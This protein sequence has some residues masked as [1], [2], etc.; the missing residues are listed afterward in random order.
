M[1]FRM[2]VVLVGG[3]AF[4]A[5]GALVDLAS[6][7]DADLAT[8]CAFHKEG[9][10]VHRCQERNAGVG[11]KTYLAQFDGTC[12]LSQG[13]PVEGG[14]SREGVVGGCETDD[15][16]MNGSRVVDW[17]YAPMS[18]DDVR[19]KCGKDPFVEPRE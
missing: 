9:Q 15:G 16:K 17:Y 19:L 13:Q 12:K 3:M 11:G 1:A 4:V 10:P 5:C 2:L 14:C 8:G 7:E 18:V 6:G